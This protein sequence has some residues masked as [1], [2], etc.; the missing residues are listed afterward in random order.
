MKPLQ[1]KREITQKYNQNPQQQ[2]QNKNI[3]KQGRKKIK[4][5]A[6]QEITNENKTYR[7]SSQIIRK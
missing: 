7:N 4:Q 2:I 5:K 6:N 3:K 1:K